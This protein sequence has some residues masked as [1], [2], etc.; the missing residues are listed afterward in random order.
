MMGAIQG[1]ITVGTITAGLITATGIKLFED[2][3][4]RV[5]ESGRG[6]DATRD[7]NAQQLAAEVNKR[8]A[9]I[10][11]R[12]GNLS[13]LDKAKDLREEWR[14]GDVLASD[15]SAIWGFLAAVDALAEPTEGAQQ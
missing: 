5:N 12:E 2:S 7:M 11:K 13:N 3:D 8:K 4:K 9:D 6:V 14:H 1:G 10:G 15:D